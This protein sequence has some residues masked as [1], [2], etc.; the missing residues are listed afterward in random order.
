MAKQKKE[1][2]DVTG[3]KETLKVRIKCAEDEEAL[4]TVEGALGIVAGND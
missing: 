1:E 2:P 4:G 3:V